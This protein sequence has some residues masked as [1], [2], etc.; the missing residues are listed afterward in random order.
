[1]WWCLLVFVVSDCE[2]E[3]EERV[4]TKYDDNINNVSIKYKAIFEFDEDKYQIIAYS[5]AWPQTYVINV[6]QFKQFDDGLYFVQR[7]LLQ[8]LFALKPFAIKTAKAA[9]EQ[10]LT[11]MQKQIDS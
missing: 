4:C 9:H 6:Y 11:A 5:Y 1:M 10:A 8:T 7:T 2:H 3:K